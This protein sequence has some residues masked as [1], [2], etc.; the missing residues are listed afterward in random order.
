MTA[1][2][3]KIS[4]LIF[5]VGD[6]LYDASVWRKWLTKQIDAMGHSVTYPQLVQSWERLLVE[7]YEGKA[8]YWPTFTKLLTELGVPESKHEDLISKS[9]QKGQ[10]VQ[11]DRE[12]MP[13]VPDTLRQLS[14]QSIKLVALSDTESGESGVRRTLD[15]LGIESYFTAVITSRDIGHAKP[16]AEAFDAAIHATGHDKSQC[17]FV[18]H[19]VDELEGAQ[20]HDLFA[21]AYN[22][23]PKAPADVFLDHF[24]D[25]LSVVK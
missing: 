21:I 24:S 18:A 14:E 23:D 1:A 17:G 10:D 2:K 15:Q 9:K 6:I 16:S 3:P 22:Y 20:T 4:A 13:G 19:D 12:P 11:V 25:L 8:E 5:D 7:V